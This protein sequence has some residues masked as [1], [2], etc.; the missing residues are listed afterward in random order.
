MTQPKWCKE[1][2]KFDFETDYPTDRESGPGS[3]TRRWVSQSRNWLRKFLVEEFGCKPEDFIY[4]RGWF[5]WTA[6]AKIGEQ[7]WYFSTG[8]I[9][10]KLMGSFLVRKADSPKDYSGHSN[11]FVNYYNSKFEEELKYILKTGS[12]NIL[13][14]LNNLYYQ[15]R[16]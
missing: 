15:D 14:S 8:D 2:V 13:S 1:Y 12:Q 6:F 3:I 7:W 11:N 4:R 16:L 10:F 5:E 9:R